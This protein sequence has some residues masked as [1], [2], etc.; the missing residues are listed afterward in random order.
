MLELV[1][2]A[3]A[4]FLGA[5]LQKISIRREKNLTKNWAQLKDARTI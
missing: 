3:D 4:I 2:T 5:F 1:D